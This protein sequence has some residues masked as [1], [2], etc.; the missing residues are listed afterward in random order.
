MR[1]DMLKKVFVLSVCFFVF[2]V[3]G[4]CNTLGVSINWPGDS[5]EV[6]NGPPDHAPAHGYRAKYRYY[7]GAHVYFDAGRRVYFHLDGDSWRMTASL[8]MDI[9]VKLG[10]YVTIEMDT[11]KP[12]TKFEKHKAKYP[13]GQLKKKNKKNK[14][15][16][17]VDY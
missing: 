12:Y 8:P 1:L 2:V 14:K 16:D 13:P 7:P 17:S 4:G 9:K 11:D 15:W 6:K 10:D 3:L 5:K